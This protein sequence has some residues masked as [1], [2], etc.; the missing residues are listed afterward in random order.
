MKHVAKIDGDGGP[1]GGFSSFGR[2]HPRRGWPRSGAA[3]GPGRPSADVSPQPGPRFSGD[4]RPWN[5]SMGKRYFRDDTPILDFI[6]A[7]SYR[8]LVAKVVHGEAQAA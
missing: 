7:L 4:G 8:F 2:N 1:F 5:W 3:L 6:P